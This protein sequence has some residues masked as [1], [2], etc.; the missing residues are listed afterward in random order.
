MN[1]N[2][3][4]VSGSILIDTADKTNRIEYEENIHVTTI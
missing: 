1:L 3:S 2:E 4:W